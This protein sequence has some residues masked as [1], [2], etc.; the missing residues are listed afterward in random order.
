M[1]IWSS[2]GVNSLYIIKFVSPNSLICSATEAER[3][4][5]NTVQPQSGA[6]FAFL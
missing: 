4:G 5:P 1:Y 2:F 3:L 6:A